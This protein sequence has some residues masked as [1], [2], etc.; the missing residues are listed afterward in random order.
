MADD[1]AGELVPTFGRHIAYL[2]LPCTLSRTCWL[3][4]LH[5]GRWGVN[6]RFAMLATEVS[7]F[8]AT[9]ECFFLIAEIV[10]INTP[11]AIAPARCYWLFWKC[12]LPLFPHGRG[13]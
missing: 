13:N 5:S 6:K 7:L 3:V 1:Q 12:R 2:G 11:N 10:E 9:T 4:R 8:V